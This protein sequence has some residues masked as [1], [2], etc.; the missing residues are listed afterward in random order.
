[1]KDIVCLRH[2]KC[3]C[4][5]GGRKGL[6]LAPCGIC[7]ANLAAAII[8]FDIHRDRKCVGPFLLSH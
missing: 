5:N 6:L 7:F 1:M 3:I 4:T 2:L 8:E